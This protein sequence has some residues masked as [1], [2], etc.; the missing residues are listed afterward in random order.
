[1]LTEEKF[2]MTRPEDLGGTISI[3]PEWIRNHKNNSLFKKMMNN[4]YDCTEN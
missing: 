3:K 4:D 2:I 1:M